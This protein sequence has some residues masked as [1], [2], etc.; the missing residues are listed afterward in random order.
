MDKMPKRQPQ[1]SRNKT[2]IKNETTRDQGANFNETLLFLKIFNTFWI[3]ST[4][5]YTLIYLEF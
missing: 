1:T 2:C 4:G 5:P 3:F